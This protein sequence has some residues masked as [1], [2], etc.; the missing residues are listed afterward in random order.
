[1]DMRFVVKDQTHDNI[2]QSMLAAGI[3]EKTLMS[4]LYYLPVDTSFVVNVD[5]T[6][7]RYEVAKVYEKTVCE[8]ERLVLIACHKNTTNSP[9]PLF[10]LWW[11]A[12]ELVALFQASNQGQVWQLDLA[13]GFWGEPW[14]P[15][16]QKMNDDGWMPY[17]QN[18][19][20]GVTKP[21]MINAVRKIGR[22]VDEYQSLMMQE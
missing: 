9:T 4:L 3:A 20:M 11:E 7:D 19:N 6:D 17:A 10:A 22:C 2:L 5:D 14:L 16:A 15:W 18:A 13:A 8:N 12:S 1:M 21:M